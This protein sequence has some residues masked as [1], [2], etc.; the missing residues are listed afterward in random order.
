MSLSTRHAPWP[1]AWSARHVPCRFVHDIRLG[2]GYPAASKC[3]PLSAYSQLAT[4]SCMRDTDNA[5]YAVDSI[6]TATI[7]TKQTGSE[8]RTRNKRNVR[9]VQCSADRPS[10]FET[11]W[12]WRENTGPHKPHITHTFFTTCV[13]D[14]FFLAFCSC[15]PAV[16]CLTVLGA[17][18][19]CFYPFFS[20]FPYVFA[21]AANP[22][23]RCFIVVPPLLLR[24]EYVTAPTTYFFFNSFFT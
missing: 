24:G 3:V 14:V 6:V 18:T 12:G 11:R 16:A 15:F 1:A 5:R 4:W 21:S 7:S 13:T 9:A 17:T 10:S 22:M 19:G 8:A 23:A 2:A 20:F